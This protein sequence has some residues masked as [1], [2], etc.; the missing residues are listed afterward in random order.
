MIAPTVGIAIDRMF[1]LERAA[2]NWMV[3]LSAVGGVKN[4]SNEG[5]GLDVMSDQIA[6]KTAQQWDAMEGIYGAAMMKEVRR[7]LDLEGAE[8]K[9]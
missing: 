3:A 8:Y 4:I 2:R 6:E 7:V 1:Y 5:A 9:E